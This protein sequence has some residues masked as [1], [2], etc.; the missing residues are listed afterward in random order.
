MPNADADSRFL[1]FLG[2]LIIVVCVASLSFAGG[3]IFEQ[4]TEYPYLSNFENFSREDF[5][6]SL[7]WDVW[8]ILEREYVDE[9]AIDR[10]AMF[11]GAIKGMVSSLDDPATIFLN[12]EESETFRKQTEGKHFE[13]IGAELGYRDGVVIIISPLEGSPAKAAGVQPGAVILKVDGEE[14]KRTET[15]FDVVKRIRGEKGTEVVLELMQGSRMEIEEITIVRDEITIPSMSLEETDVDGIYRI[16]VGRFTEA[17][18]AVWNGVWNNTVQEFLETGSD[19]LILDLRGNPGG[20]F[21][22]GI[23]AAEEF[24]QKGTLVAKQEDRQGNT[25]KYEV[26][27]EGELLDVDVVVL[28][29]EGSASSSEILAGALQK[30]NRA[31]VIGVETYGKGTAQRMVDLYDGSTLHITIVKWLLPDGTWINP[32]NVIIPDIEVEL[33]QEDF[34]EGLDPQLEKA[35]EV[36]GK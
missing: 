10:E 24:L 11:Y 16:K 28:V 27:R 4:R 32:E 8:N 22:A 17:S 1:R 33:T 18:L 6:S 29:N 3:R 9:E 31:R 13:G 25:Q 12:A 2:V 26:S 14:V 15:V 30:A 7:F 5:D 23:H 36:L 35:L 20:F 21:D 19:K 34:E